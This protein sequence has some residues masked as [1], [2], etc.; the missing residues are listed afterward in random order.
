MKQLFQ[1]ILNFF[2][3][4]EEEYH[5]KKSHRTILIVVGTLFSIL[6]LILLGVMIASGLLGALLPL[7]IF[8][9]AGLV[10]LVVGTLGSERAVAKLWGNTANK[11]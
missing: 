1:P 4:G 7:I 3:K 11:K 9:A 6:A 8:S 5:Y 2:E 10:C